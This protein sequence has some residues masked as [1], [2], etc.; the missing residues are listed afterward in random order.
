MFEITGLN[1]ENS[2]AGQRILSVKAERFSVQRKR[3]GFLRL[4]S[5]NIGAFERAE[6]L[7]FLEFGEDSRNESADVEGDEHVKHNF[8]KHSLPLYSSGK[9]AS[10][11]LNPARFILVDNH[12]STRTGITSDSAIISPEKSSIEFSGKVEAIYKNRVLKTRILILHVEQMYMEAREGFILTEPGS[13]SEG[14][15]I[16]VDLFLNMLPGA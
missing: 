8:L 15:K 5:E 13:R 6:F 7:Y 1:Y 3:R 12:S 9:I 16:R 10:Y 2:H 4:R 11:V 14:V